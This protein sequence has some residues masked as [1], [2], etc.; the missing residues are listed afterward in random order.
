[1]VT[2]RD[3]VWSAIQRMDSAGA[4]F[5]RQQLMQQELAA[6]VQAVGST[7]ATPAQTLSRVLQELRDDGV[8]IFDGQGS[9]RVAAGVI[10][11]TVEEAVATEAWRLQKARVGQ[12]PFRAALLD[13]WGGRCPLTGISEPALLRA[14]HIVPW[15]RC[16]TDAERL[17]PENGLLLSAL[18]DAAFDRGLVTFADDGAAVPLPGLAA[19]SFSVVVAS[20]KDR[21]RELS[22]GNR[23]RLRWHRRQWQSNDSITH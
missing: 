10:T 3:A 12:G 19:S 14:S 5:T 20:G 2:W 21:L 9:Y 6:I 23:E 4:A 1:M 15:N 11:Q 7:G 22:D 17:N 8:L 13:R 18:W 16:E